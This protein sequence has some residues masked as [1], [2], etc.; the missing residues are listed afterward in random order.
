VLAGAEGFEASGAG[1]A[2]GE[3]AV[4]E[5]CCVLGVV[6]LLDPL[7]AEGVAWGVTAGGLAVAP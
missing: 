6:E 4:L 2:L 7:A 3:V 5:A 1:D